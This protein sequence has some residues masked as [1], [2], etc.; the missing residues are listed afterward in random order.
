MTIQA[1]RAQHFVSG[2]KVVILI[3][4]HGNDFFPLA[5]GNRAG[6][7]TG[8][9]RYARSWCTG[10]LH[11]CFPEQLVWRASKGVG[12][13][14]IVALHACISSRKLDIKAMRTM[15]GNA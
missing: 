12:M 3:V 8:G 6:H 10:S 13:E 5:D 9:A 4:L 15:A 14:I 2:T 1:D 7:M 11:L